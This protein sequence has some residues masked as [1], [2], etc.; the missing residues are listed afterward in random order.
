MRIRRK[1][2]LFSRLC[3]VSDYLLI[4]D[5]DV[6]D[7][8]EAGLKKDYIDLKSVFGNDNPVRMEVGC[9][10]GG[11]AVESAVREPEV[12]FFAVEL[13]DNI[14]VMAAELAKEKAVPNVKFF[15]CGADYLARYIKPLSLQ[16]I[17]LN[18]SPPFPGKRYENRRLTKDELVKAYKLFLKD[19]GEVLQKTDEKEFFDY[20]FDQF[21]KF[22]FSV[23]DISDKIN[24]EEY[25][26][27]ETEY[28]KKFREKGMPVYALS[29]VKID[30]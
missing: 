27:V 13:L 20:S 21:K 2:N 9:G 26:N 22:G 8:R 23:T 7:A 16:K 15:N 18:F 14:V 10:K 19:G 24:A 17:Y 5:G 25:G 3:A 30:F 28:E 4:S 29:A 6:L 1:R 11:F 12:N